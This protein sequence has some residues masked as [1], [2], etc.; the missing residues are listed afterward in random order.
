MVRANAV[1]CMQ[2]QCRGAHDGLPTMEQLREY[3]LD[4]RFVVE[5]C[6]EF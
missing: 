2:I 5:G 1:G 3:M 6:K 4:H